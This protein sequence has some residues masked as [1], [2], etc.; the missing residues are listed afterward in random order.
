[1]SM[2]SNSLMPSAC[3]T[4]IAGLIGMQAMALG[5]GKTICHR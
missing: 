3:E 1:M 2:M 5:I 4:D